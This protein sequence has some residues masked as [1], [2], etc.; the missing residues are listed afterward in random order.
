VA[1]E[2]GCAVRHFDGSVVEYEPREA[3]AFRGGVAC[4]RERGGSRVS[5]TIAA[6]LQP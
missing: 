6:L 5:S 2:A 3:I 1:R 4:W